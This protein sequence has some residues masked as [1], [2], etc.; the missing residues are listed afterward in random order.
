MAR[1][2]KGKST[3]INGERH[4]KASS[5][6]HGTKINVTRNNAYT[7]SVSAMCDVLNLPTSTYYYHADLSGSVRE[8]LKIQ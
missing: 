2:R 8:R 4:F 6:D 5:A 1:L 7:Y 3:F